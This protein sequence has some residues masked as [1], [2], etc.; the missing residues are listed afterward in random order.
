MSPPISTDITSVTLSGSQLLGVNSLELAT[1]AV[2]VPLT[3]PT[4]T[5]TTIGASILNLESLMLPNTAISGAIVQASTSGAV[6][7]SLTFGASGPLTFVE[8]Q[9][10]VIATSGGS[11]LKEGGA[12][13][14]NMP[15]CMG[16]WDKDTHITKTKWR[17]ICARTL[18][19][20]HMY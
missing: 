10:E 16:A 6:P 18:T 3:S 7:G 4:A 9:G 12:T 19:V 8:S 1:P 13:G 14:R 20:E 15:E 5:T 17:E 2:S 11:S